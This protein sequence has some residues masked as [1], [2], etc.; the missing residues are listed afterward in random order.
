MELGLWQASCTG[1]E[2]RKHCCVCV[3]CS[4]L[5]VIVVIVVCFDF[6]GAFPFGQVFFTEP[7]MGGNLAL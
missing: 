2:E 1:S 6:G 7:K 4:V 3:V 5:C